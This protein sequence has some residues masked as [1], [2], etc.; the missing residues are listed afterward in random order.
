MLQWNCYIFEDSV[1]IIN[2][3]KHINYYY[4]EKKHKI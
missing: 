1:N 4:I 2:N 3:F